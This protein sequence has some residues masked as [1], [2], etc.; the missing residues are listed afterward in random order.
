MLN[1]ANCKPG[2]EQYKWYK[3]TNRKRK[4]QYDYRTPGGTL[5]SCIANTLR[6]ARQKRDEWVK[7]NGD[8]E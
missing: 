2:T 1:P 4:V 6:D 5:F 7:N 3:L 8:K